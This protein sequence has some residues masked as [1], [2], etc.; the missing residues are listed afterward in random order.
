MAIR[1]NVEGGTPRAWP[2]WHRRGLLALLEAAADGGEDLS[3]AEIPEDVVRWV[4]ETGLG[5]LLVRTVA[6]DRDA[7]RSPAWPALHGADLAA[8]VVAAEQA[9]ALTALADACAGAVRPLALLKGIAMAHHHYPSPH[10]GPMRDLDIL[11]ARP[12]VL[13][14]E[15]ALRELGYRPHSKNPPEYYVT[16]H[17]GMPFVHPR[18]GIWVEVHHALFPPANPLARDA[19]FGRRHVE[20]EVRPCELHGRPVSRFSDELRSCTRPRTGRATSR[21]PRGQSRCST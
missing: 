10:L 12:A 6:R 2:R 16:H 21:S 14:V 7:T 17:H 5:S 19:V 20:T 13:T 9:D 15:S 18:T 1:S 4:L 8:Q 11:V 3:L